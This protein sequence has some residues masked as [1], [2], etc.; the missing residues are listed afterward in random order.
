MRLLV[1]NNCGMKIRPS[2]CKIYV[3]PLTAIE[4]AGQDVETDGAHQE[5]MRTLRAKSDYISKTIKSAQKSQNDNLDFRTP[6]KR[7]GLVRTQART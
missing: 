3:A 6:K 7:N 1:T 4:N 5:R 2:T